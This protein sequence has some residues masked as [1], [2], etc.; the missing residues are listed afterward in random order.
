MM[1]QNF[2]KKESIDSF[3][4]FLK[5]TDGDL[6]FRIWMEIE[7]LAMLKNENEKKR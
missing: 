3:K 7:T 4:S 2:V 1:K 5:E 6:F